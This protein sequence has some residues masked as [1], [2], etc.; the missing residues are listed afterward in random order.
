[1]VTAKV[2]KKGAQNGQLY[3]YLCQRDFISSEGIIDDINGI[4]YVPDLDHLKGEL[5]C[6]WVTLREMFF[7][8]EASQTLKVLPE[9]LPIKLN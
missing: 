4:A 6:I 7:Y 2:Y 9:P 3:L 5:H 8:K 1:M